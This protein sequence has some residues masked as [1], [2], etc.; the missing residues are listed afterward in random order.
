MGVQMQGGTRPRDALTNVLAIAIAVALAAIGLAYALDALNRK[1]AETDS[2]TRFFAMVPVNVSGVELEIPSN[3]LRFSSQPETPF[4]DRLDLALPLDFSGATPV[5]ITLT[6][7]PRAR[8]RASSTLLDSVY[9]QHF[10]AEETPGVPGLVGK[11]LAGGEG[12]QEETVWYDPIR[13]N[14]FVAK[15]APPL[16]KDEQGICLR[17]LV[18]DSG[19]AAILGFPETA[20]QEWRRFDALLATVFDRIGAGEILR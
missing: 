8:V 7:V 10:S 20:L 9:L 14:P 19:L 16:A 18:L 2:T 17:T 11:P 1:N 15:C 12:Y 4:S 5:Q 3:W 6:I 13:I